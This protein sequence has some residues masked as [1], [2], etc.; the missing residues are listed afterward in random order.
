MVGEHVE[1]MLLMASIF[2]GKLELRSGA[3]GEEAEEVFVV[4]T[5]KYEIDF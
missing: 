1:V 4:R 2:S 3:G 5:N